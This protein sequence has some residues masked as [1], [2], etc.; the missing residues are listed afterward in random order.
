M[1]NVYVTRHSTTKTFFKNI[2]NQTLNQ[3][4]VTNSFS[5]EQNFNISS[6]SESKFAQCKFYNY[7]AFSYLISKGPNFISLQNIKT[8]IYAMER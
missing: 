8:L 7:D 1:H 6:I 2:L 3:R 5:I 4:F